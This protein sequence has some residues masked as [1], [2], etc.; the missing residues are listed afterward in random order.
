MPGYVRSQDRTECISQHENSQPHITTP[1][2]EEYMDAIRYG[3]E[4]RPL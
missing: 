1:E 2:E 3:L 4:H